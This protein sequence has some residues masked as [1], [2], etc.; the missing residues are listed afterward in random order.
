MVISVGNQ[1]DEPLFQI[2]YKIKFS[3]T[4]TEILK[5]ILLSN[6]KPTRGPRNDL[7]WG[8]SPSWISLFPSVR[9]HLGHAVICLSSFYI[10][11]T[12]HSDRL[13][14]KTSIWQI[15]ANPFVTFRQKKK[16]PLHHP[17]WFF[18]QIILQKPVNPPYWWRWFRKLHRKKSAILQLLP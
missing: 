4:S 10:P 15:I 1:A 7:G 13:G 9:P 14:T 12:C 18:W 2:R 8:I 17:T 16:S 5:S 3:P 6:S 11:A